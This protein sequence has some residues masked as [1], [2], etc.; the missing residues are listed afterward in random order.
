M[1]IYALWVTRVAGPLIPEL[2]LAWDESQDWPYPVVQVP[3]PCRT[4]RAMAL[5]FA[6]RPSVREEWRP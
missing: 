6:D 1:K 5:P 4:L 3:A 2:V